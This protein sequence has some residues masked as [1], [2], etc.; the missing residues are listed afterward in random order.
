MPHPKKDKLRILHLGR[1]FHED[2][3]GGIERHVDALLSTIG[4]NVEADNLVAALPGQH[5][6]E[7]P[8]LKSN[9]RVFIAPSWGNFAST[10]IAPAMIRMARKLHKE[11]K[12][13]ILHLH[14]PDPLSQLVAQMLPAELPRVV[15][16]HSD[17]IRQKRL[18]RLYKP[19]LNKFLPTVEALIAP[20]AAHFSSST[21]IN[22]VPESRR[23][24]IPFGLDYKIFDGPEIP[25]M[26]ENLRRNLSGNRPLILAAGRHV[27]YKGYTYLIKAMQ[28]LPEVHLALV[29]EGPLSSTLRNQ[30]IS[31]NVADRVHFLGRISDMDLAACYRACD[32]FCLPS[33]SQAEAFGLVQL[34]A[35]ACG[36]PVICSNLNNGVNQ[37]NP[38]GVSGLSFPPA[39][40]EAITR[41]ISKLVTNKNLCQQLGSAGY[42][43]ARTLYSLDRMGEETIL[44]YE[45]ILQKYR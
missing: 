39:D 33:I 20:T 35:M 31:E 19:F 14:F 17:I 37:L 18:L 29:G 38:N 24:V 21:Q 5:V 6:D 13:Q 26:A 3:S 2:G 36:K 30:A 16:W 45:K 12:Y 22:Q 40:P 15:T 9:Y 23:F 41:V 4:N 32:I 1:F 7:R 34:E 25:Q 27:P 28:Q 11:R 10:A 43:R 8:I 44:L 42:E